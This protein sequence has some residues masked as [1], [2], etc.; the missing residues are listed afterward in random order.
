MVR[1]TD[2]PLAAATGQEFRVKD[3]TV[4]FRRDGR[5]A[6]SGRGAP[7]PT[8]QRTADP[9]EVDRTPRGQQRV[10][11]SQGYQPIVSGFTP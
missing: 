5:R 9:D 8:T 11:G 4:E 10:H 1:A 7:G 6:A 2:R 3:R